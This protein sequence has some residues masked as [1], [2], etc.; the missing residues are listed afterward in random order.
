M[1]TADLAK[2]LGVRNSDRKPRT[3]RSWVVR[4]G[5]R[6]RDL[7]WMMSCCI[8]IRFSGSAARLPP[9]AISLARVVRT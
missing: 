6:G 9:S 2:R 4:F 3:V 7:L 1:M 5:A 8:R